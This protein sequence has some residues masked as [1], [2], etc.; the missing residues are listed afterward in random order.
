[1]F[2]E[3]GRKIIER[4][5]LGYSRACPVGLFLLLWLRPVRV[6]STILMTLSSSIFMAISAIRFCL[7]EDIGDSESLHAA[8]RNSILLEIMK[9]ERILASDS[10]ICGVGNTHL[11]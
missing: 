5:Y 11:L 1:M 9:S 8:K 4:G 7:A 6:G 2:L 10:E 3:V